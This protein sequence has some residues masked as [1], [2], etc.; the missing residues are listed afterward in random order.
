MSNYR[1][2][3][4]LSFDTKNTDQIGIHMISE[5]YIPPKPNNYLVDKFA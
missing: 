4:A 3:L 5:S 2:Q 1:S